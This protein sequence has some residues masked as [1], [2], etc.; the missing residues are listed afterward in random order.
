MHQVL[1]FVV[2]LYGYSVD[3]IE[4]NLN[5]SCFH[6]PIRLLGYSI[7]Y[8]Y[9]GIHHGRQFSKFT[10]GL[11]IPGRDVKN[12]SNYRMPCLFKTNPL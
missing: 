7:L 6:L 5:L 3:E 1:L 8:R 2:N 10:F 11:G 9:K 4:L 12:W